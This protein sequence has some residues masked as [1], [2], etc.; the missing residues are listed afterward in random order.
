MMLCTKLPLQTAL[1]R[2]RE[3]SSALPVRAEE[4]LADVVWGTPGL[5]LR[6]VCLET[7]SDD[8]RLVDSQLS[9]GLGESFLELMSESHGDGHS[10]SNDGGI[11]GLYHS[12]ATARPLL[13]CLELQVLVGRR[14]EVV[15]DQPEPGLGDAP[16]DPVEEG[17][18]VERQEHHALVHE[19][20]DLVERSLALLAVHLRRLLAEQR[21]EIRIAAVGVRAFR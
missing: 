8:L 17:R 14:V 7:S 13:L 21:I 4:A 1:E 19:L 10:C 3:I 5:H 16:A 15:T 2:R 11:L 6:E 20:L 12:I 9:A 18:L